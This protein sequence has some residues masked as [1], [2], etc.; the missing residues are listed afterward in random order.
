VPSLKIDLIVDDKGQV[1]INNAKAKFGELEQAVTKTHG[2]LSG[3]S[4]MWGKIAAIT[5]GAMSLA[6]IYSLVTATAKAKDELVETAEKAG[7][8]AT[9][10]QLYQYAGKMVG[11]E[12]ETATK[13]IQILSRNMYDA[14]SGTGKAKDAFAALGISVKD[15]SGNL[16]SAD[17]MLLELADRFKGMDDGAGKTALAMKVFG[18][19]GAEM[20]PILN[21][22]ADGLGAMK[23]RM[24]ELGYE[25]DEEKIRRVADL[26]DRFDEMRVVAGN[27]GM[28][29]VS[30]LTPALESI[31]NSMGNASNS[32]EGMRGV[33]S[34]LGDVLKGLMAAGVAVV[35]GFD[36]MGTKI[37]ETVG[38]V[39]VTV[40]KLTSGIKQ[41]VTGGGKQ[42]LV[43]ALLTG[44]GESA[45]P[46][47]LTYYKNLI[48][49]FWTE[50]A[51]TA[52]KAKTGASKTPAPFIPDE[53]VVKDIEKAKTE[54]ASLTAEFM[55]WSS[56][57]AETNPL[58]SEQDKAMMKLNEEAVKFRKG[59]I[60]E[61]EI[62]IA[63]ATAE[64]N[65]A[66]KAQEKAVQDT[67]EAAAKSFEKEVIAFRKAADDKVAAD[68]LAATTLQGIQEARLGPYEK[69]LLDI[70]KAEETAMTAITDSWMKGDTSSVAEWEKYNTD[71]QTIQDYYSGLR[72]DAEHQE[73][74]D[75]EAEWDAAN[76]YWDKVMDD[77]LLASD[78]F[79]GGMALR[80]KQLYGPDGDM[81]T[82]AKE[83][84]RLFDATSANMSNT[85][86]TMFVD[87]Y[88]GEL[89]TAKDYWVAFCDSMVASFA[90][91]IG[92]MASQSVMGAIFGGSEGGGGWQTLV[93]IGSTVVN[94]GE[95]F[96]DWVVSLW[97]HEGGIIGSSGKAGLVPA[98]V[99]AGAKRMHSGGLA[100]DE[101]PVILQQG[102]LVIPKDVVSSI[103]QAGLAGSGMAGLAFMSAVPGMIGANA[104]LGSLGLAAGVAGAAANGISEAMPPMTTGTYQPWQADLQ[105]IA[106]VL[107]WAST[108]ISGVSLIGGITGLGTLGAGGKGMGRGLSWASKGINA[109]LS[110]F[111]IISDLS[112]AQKAEVFYSGIGGQGGDAG[113]WASSM[114]ASSINAYATGTDYVPRTG[115]Y[116]L[117]QGE[118][119][120]PAGD[121]A[122]LR[123][124]LRAMR[125]EMVATNQETARTSLRMLRLVE[126]WEAI[127]M[128]QTRA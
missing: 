26:N 92:K 111:G 31:M 38:A 99:F 44:P 75:T 89:N 107:G 76:V 13:A 21:L 125:I 115:P 59:G 24:V 62:D 4:D 66:F 121:S 8:A 1:T 97:E 120:I 81:D 114:E 124:E 2:S 9:S 126:Q 105:T 82:W 11:V 53:K 128:P 71:R 102:E 41:L 109:I 113:S 42:G 39:V 68:R 33:G 37:G 88:H 106:S 63:L 73:V 19:S 74:L 101:V 35:A 25:M 16:K 78:D 15:S 94:K 96:V 27:L 10:L 22:G 104:A 84:V 12:M 7:I 48:G 6:G 51:A 72:V 108:A 47:K 69:T 91:S 86:S 49:G 45:L 87:A 55:K 23:D 60:P 56:G 100:S 127:G 5:G 64:T 61:L 70:T 95:E 46:D 52:E 36:I 79:F 67:A 116:I 58:L 119:V 18:K 80:Y 90:E 3:L 28:Q 98:S 43:D 122:S 17:S 83:G 40:T 93:N 57:V 32:M 123:E 77:Q 54:F 30:G 50:T 85:F 112:D 20:L 14:A 110:Y 29:L 103:E 117:H 118:A 65:L 34:V